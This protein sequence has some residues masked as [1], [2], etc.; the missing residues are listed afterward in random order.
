MKK[1]K[2]LFV[3]LMVWWVMKSG[4]TQQ[5]WLLASARCLVLNSGDGWDGWPGALAL[6]V[7]RIHWFSTLVLPALAG[8]P[9]MAAGSPDSFL[10]AQPLLYLRYSHSKMILAYVWYQEN[11]SGHSQ[12][13]G[14]AVTSP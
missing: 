14:I 3:L 11:S 13:K 10:S 9:G 8:M 12:S 1:S 5:K 7:S 2:T 4:W 6:S